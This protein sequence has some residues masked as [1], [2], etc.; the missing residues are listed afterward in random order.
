MRTNL[1]ELR[2]PANPLFNGDP[3]EDDDAERLAAVLAAIAD[4]ARLRILSL[5]DCSNFSEVSVKDLTDQM[6]LSQPTVSHHLRILH[7]AGLLR[8]DKR[9]VWVYYSITPNAI[10]AV[11]DL[12]APR[13]RGRKASGATA[14]GAPVS[15][16]APASAA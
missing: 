5:I 6:K 14:S 13:K 12:L 4:P 16:E 8:R 9:S 11:L 3:Y 15:S 1:A 7:Q 2:L 10:K